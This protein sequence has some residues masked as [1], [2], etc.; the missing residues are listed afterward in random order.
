MG[1]RN[2]TCV[3]L[4]NEYK[5]AQYGQWDGYP[6]GTGLDILEFLRKNDL[7]VFKE[8]VSK[9][10]LHTNEYEYNE[11]LPIE[12]SRNTGGKILDV[13]INGE[14]KELYSSL[15]FANYSL[16]CEWGYVIDFDKNTFEVYE[17]FNE[18]ILNKSERFYNNNLSDGNYYPIKF[19]K[20]YDLNSLPTNEEFLKDVDV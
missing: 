5:V 17:G 13:I 7:N 12:Y 8:K 14:I 11:N 1:T 15:D 16:F 6:S 4:N 9:I 3:V 18:R 19:I 20:S 2:L 10:K